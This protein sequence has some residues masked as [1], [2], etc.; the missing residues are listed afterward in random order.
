MEFIQVKKD[1]EP[2]IALIQ[3]NRPKELNALNLQLMGEL[4]DALKEIDQDGDALIQQEELR[5]FV[6]FGLKLSKQDREDYA[7]RGP[8]QKIIVKF[9]YG[10][11][12]AARIH[13]KDQHWKLY[14]PQS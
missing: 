12:G 1:H 11:D 4:R 6:S 13:A 5:E 14:N 3:L 10:L 8:L 2:H 7:A 9:F